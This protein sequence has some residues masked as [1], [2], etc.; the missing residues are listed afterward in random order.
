MRHRQFPQLTAT[1]ALALLC[2]WLVLACGRANAG[3]TLDSPHFNLSI[4]P[5]LSY[6]VDDGNR[7]TARDFTD[8]ALQQQF[9]PARTPILRLGYTSSTLWLRLQLD[10]E[11]DQ[12]R[13]ALLYLTRPNIGLMRVY[14]M[15]GNQVSLVGETKVVGVYGEKA[16]DL[17][18]PCT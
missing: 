15:N 5:D 14:R 9:T 16:L 13:S 4:L 10:N 6:F 18:I 7:F 8:P 1:T 3:V 11:Q 2:V 12:A 17:T